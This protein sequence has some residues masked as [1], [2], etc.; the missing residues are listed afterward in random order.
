MKV[1]MELTVE[2]EIL[3]SMLLRL[4]SFQDMLSR[5]AV[6]MCHKRY[7]TGLEPFL[8]GHVLYTCSETIDIITLDNLILYFIVIM[9]FIKY[10]L[11]IANL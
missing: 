2:I 6:E 1:A 7:F 9:T 8:K 10:P 11:N 5:H 4:V 3:P